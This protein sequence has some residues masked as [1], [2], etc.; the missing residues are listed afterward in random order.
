MKL[1]FSNTICSLLL[2]IICPVVASSQ[3]SINNTSSPPHESAMLDVESSSRGFL[4]PRMTSAERDAISNPT[5]GLQIFN[6]ETE[7]LQ[8]FT[9]SNGW[10]SV[11]GDDLCA[12]FSAS[13]SW[14]LSVSC[15]GA[16]DGSAEVATSGG[17]PPFSYSWTGDVS[18]GATATNLPSGLYEVTVEDSKGC[19]DEVTI[20]IT[21]PDPLSVSISSNSPVTAGTDLNLTAEPVGGT[22]PYS[23]VWGGPESFSSSEQNPV[24]Q[25]VQTN[26][27]GTYTL[28]LSDSRG[29]TAN[30]ANGVSVN[31]PW[32]CGQPFTMVH[33]ANDVAPVSKTV[34]YETVLTSIGG[35]SRCWITQNLGADVQ[36]SSAGDMSD[37][38]A[39]WYWQFNRKQGWANGSVGGWPNSLPDVGN[40][41]SSEDPCT[42]LLGSGWRLPTNT[43]MQNVQSGIS[44]SA[45]AYS[46]ILKLHMAGSLETSTGALQY[47]GMFGHY[48]DSEEGS[49]TDW[50]KNLLFYSS[51]AISEY[52]KQHG[53]PVRCV[54]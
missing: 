45:A 17:V 29:C 39:G 14:V 48:W 54:Q 25:N 16:T 5:P 10:L 41:L 21:I 19:Q 3:V 4:P 6:T 42:L 30:T 28:N 52:H 43:E 44:N 40:W 37:A 36:A 35:D 34:T 22:P 26:Q 13:L 2:F 31:D 49:N 8:F 38:A 11:C 27:S 24:I 53:F 9:A 15:P 12:N 1:S 51:S 46:S 50:G 47:R 23:Y 7:C 20:L 18:N 33:S 32:S